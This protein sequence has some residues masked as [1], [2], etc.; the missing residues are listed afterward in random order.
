[1]TGFDELEHPGLREPSAGDLVQYGP[2]SEWGERVYAEIDGALRDGR[3]DLAEDAA[4]LLG[5]AIETLDNFNRLLAVA[6]AGEPGALKLLSDRFQGRPGAQVWRDL[7]AYAGRRPIGPV[8]DGPCGVAGIDLGSVIWVDFQLNGGRLSPPDDPRMTGADGREPTAP[9]R[10]NFPG[11][12]EPARSDA[13]PPFAGGW[14]GRAM[15]EYG[16]IAGP[17]EQVLQAGRGWLDSGD[18]DGLPGAFDGLRELG[19]GG[20]GDPTF[21]CLDEQQVCLGELL[22]FSWERLRRASF[23]APGALN[24]ASVCVGYGG[25][26][27]VTPAT[28]FPA[29]DDAGG[30]FPTIDHQVAQVVSWTTSEILLSVPASIAP[31]CHSVGWGFLM[32]P[33]AVNDLRA[34]GEQCLPWFPR[35]GFKAFPLLIWNEGQELTFS[36]IGEPTAAFAANGVSTLTVE[37][38]TPVTLTWSV[39]LQACAQTVARRQVSML[40]NGQPFRSTLA[41]DGQLVV[42]DADDATYTLIAAS[43]LGSLSCAS[44]RR[45]VT[46]SRTKL[47]RIA[48]ILD[49]CVDTGTTVRLD[50]TTSCLAPAGGLPITISSSDPA[51]V[52]NGG[53][54]LGEGERQASV[55]MLAGASCGPVTLT[56]SAPGHVPAQVSV[57]IV[58]APQITALSP[59]SVLTCDRVEITVTGNCLGDPGLPPVGAFLS[60][61]GQVLAATVEVRNAQTNVRLSHDALP[62]GAYVVALSNCGRQSVAAAPLIVTNRP[63]QITAPLSANATALQL[64]STPTLTLRWKVRFVKSVRLFRDG[65]LITQRS[66]TDVCATHSDS[67]TDTPGQIRTSVSYRLDA[68]NPDGVLTSSTL[69]LQ[70]DSAWPIRGAFAVVNGRSE[71]MNVFLLNGEDFGGTFIGTLASG[72]GANVM[73]PDCRVRAIASVV[74]RLVAEHNANFPNDQFSPTAVD[75][76]R[77]A[78]AGWNGTS[79][80]PCLGRPGASPETVN[81]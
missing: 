71:A 50:I 73:I 16:A 23:P 60:P 81:L 43:R 68:I 75:T 64:C 46:I 26:I 39:G 27:R 72:A 25:L 29:P 5:S 78:A 33:D 12:R 11:G 20:R 41:P 79:S 52:A 74:P 30:I 76:A 47:L 9:G 21:P 77:T 48:P 61:S 22:N 17:I 63:P 58:A 44:V 36:V 2:L 38:C 15:T 49:R 55:D 13:E 24:P 69:S 45:D 62:A 35:N 32:D 80:G 66:Y 31:G 65:A 8:Y 19:L 67:A 56:V 42:A 6:A 40:R 28:S 18:I 59:A 4:R 14:S 70:A 54:R 10:P 53:F 51:R 7:D 34:I 3:F 57:V 37:A 1:M